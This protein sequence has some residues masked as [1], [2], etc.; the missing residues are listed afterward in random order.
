MGVLLCRRRLV[1]RVLEVY[2]LLFLLWIL[3]LFSQRIFSASVDEFSSGSGITE[4]TREIP[5]YFS[6]QVWV[7]FIC[8]GLKLQIEIAGAFEGI[9]TEFK[10][11]NWAAMGRLYDILL[12]ELNCGTEWKYRIH[13]SGFRVGIEWNY[14]LTHRS[15]S[16]IIC[17][18]LGIRHET[19]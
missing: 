11:K 16:S 10:V 4:R 3:H 9:K 12:C 14:Y 19:L 1:V 8:I 7:V 13:H 6:F 2:S 17:M 5:I 15:S 18:D